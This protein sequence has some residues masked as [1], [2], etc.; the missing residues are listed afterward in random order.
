MQTN[1]PLSTRK[2]SGGTGDTE[3]QTSCPVVNLWRE[4]ARAEL[5]LKTTRVA[6]SAQ[7]GRS[8]GKSN[9]G[10]R[11]DEGTGTRDEQGI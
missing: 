7:A 5:F 4:G 2:Q 9:V 3:V 6:Q 10:A 11:Y 1:G 8:R